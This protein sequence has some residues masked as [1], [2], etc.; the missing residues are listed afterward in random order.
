MLKPAGTSSFAIVGVG[1]SDWEGVPEGCDLLAAHPDQPL[2]ASI[3]K[4]DPLPHIWIITDCA[5]PETLEEIN[6]TL[7]D[8]TAIEP[9]VLLAGLNCRQLVRRYRRREVDLSPSS[10]PDTKGRIIQLPDQSFG[11]NVMLL[12]GE[13]LAVD[14]LGNLSQDG[15]GGPEIVGFNGVYLFDF[16]PNLRP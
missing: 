3:R 7:A 12:D 4:G 13:R 14:M 8:G 2:V 16:V 10:K 6:K 9:D 1:V 5:D 11:H 15:P